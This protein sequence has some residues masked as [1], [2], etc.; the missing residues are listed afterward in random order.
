MKKTLCSLLIIAIIMNFIL[1]SVSYAET[2]GTESGV[3]TDVL[4]GDG[5]AMPTNTAAA[6]ILEDGLVSQ[7]NGEEA[8]LHTNSTISGMTMIG[9]I[10]GYLALIV[11]AIPLQ[12][13]LIFSIMTMNESDDNIGDNFFLTIEKIVFNKVALFNINYLIANVISFSIAV[14]KIVDIKIPLN[15]NSQCVIIFC[16]L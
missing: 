12:F 15:I 6:G 5:T 11:D 8:T 1:S 14:L 13:Q 3:L 10:M 16:V 4:L 2:Y 9:V 7:K